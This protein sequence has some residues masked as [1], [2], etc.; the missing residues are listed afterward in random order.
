MPRV[1]TI[2][3]ILLVLPACGPSA[4]GEIRDDGLF[5]DP[6]GYCISFAQKPDKVFINNDWLV[7]DWI[8]ESGF[9][10]YTKKKGKEY[11]GNILTDADDDGT[12]E[13]TPGYFF[14]L[15]L[16]NKKTN[17]VIWIQ[18]FDMPAKHEQKQLD[19]LLDNYVDSLAGTGYYIEGNIYS[20][21]HSKERKYATKIVQ[22]QTTTLGNRNA[23]RARIEIADIDQQKFNPDTPVDLLEVVI[24]KVPIEKMLYNPNVGL[25]T[26]KKGKAIL[27]LG[28]LNSAP[29]FEEYLD[30]FDVFLKL[31][32]FYSPTSR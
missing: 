19:V 23:I 4:K 9:G 17:G 7:D 30:D 29:H 13:S 10:G 14:D 1:L 8:Y 24:L 18:T 5:I 12:M 25:N 20:L 32:K 21:L 15:K 22:Q 11:Y 31:I 16:I 27:L 3:L 26:T 28:Y 6:C 2:P